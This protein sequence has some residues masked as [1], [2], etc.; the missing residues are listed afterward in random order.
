M[1]IMVKLLT[2]AA[3]LQGSTSAAYC[4]PSAFYRSLL[5]EDQLVSLF[6]RDAIAAAEP[7]F[8]YDVSIEITRGHI[9]GTDL[10]IDPSV[11]KAVVRCHEPGAV[12]VGGRRYDLPGLGQGDWKLALWQSVC[13]TPTS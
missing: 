4:Q 6:L 13:T 10:Y 7:G 5:G 2:A 11:H 3:A 9:H 8:D 12:M 1:S